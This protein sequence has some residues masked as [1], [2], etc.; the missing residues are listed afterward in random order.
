MDLPVI[1]IEQEKAQEAF[2]EYRDAVRSTS[3]EKYA[4]ARR[5]YEA[6]DRAVMRGYK[7]IAKGHQLLQLSEALRIGGV[8]ERT[9]E[10]DHWQDGK[11]VRRTFA[12][13]FPRLAISRADARH[14]FCSG[15]Q[16]DGT[17]IFTADD[18]WSR[19]KADE[20]R[21]ERVFDEPESRNTRHH[22]AIVP[23]IPPPLRPPHKLSGY[24]ILWEAEW[25]LQA[26][27]DPALL[28]HLGGDLYAVLA[29]WDLSDLEQ[30]VLGGLRAS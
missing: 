6:I 13:T 12:G 27:V 11:Y 24:H 14:V 1:E 2:Q 8:E 4:E 17:V 26:P 22:R 16:R 10:D 15:I 29:V 18:R 5:D 9:W 30:A 7:E 19:R 21:A 25:D 3:K 20:V 28:R 23:T